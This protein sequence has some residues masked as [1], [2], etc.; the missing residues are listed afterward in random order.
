MRFTVT[1]TGSRPGVAVPQLYLR[2]EV[3]STVKP[4]YTLAAFTRVSLEPGERREV[5]LTIGPKAMRTVDPKYHWSV[6]PGRFLVALGDNA[7]NLLLHTAFT[8]AASNS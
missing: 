2:D 4:E 6:E 3:S 8:V 5:T 1:N 7:Q